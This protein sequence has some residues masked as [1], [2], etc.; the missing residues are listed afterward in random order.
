MSNDLYFRL[1]NL[2]VLD[3]SNF[4]ELESD[5]FDLTQKNIIDQLISL[6]SNNNISSKLYN[7]LIVKKTKLGS[8]SIL[9]K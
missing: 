6:K 5:P 4:L 2:H 8:L 9:P 1:C 7:A 3:T